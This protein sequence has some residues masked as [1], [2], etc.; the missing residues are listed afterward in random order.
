MRKIN[1]ICFSHIFKYWLVI[2]I[3]C[4]VYQL[5]SQELDNYSIKTVVLDPGHGGK[6]P[7]A[8]GKNCKEKDITLKVAKKVGALINKHYPQIKVAYTHETDTF[9]ALKDR[10]KFA[11]EQNADLFISIHCNSF[12]KNRNVSGIETYVMGSHKAEDNLN[13]SL[14]E[15]AV[16]TYEENYESKYEGYDPNSSESLII[17]SMIQN[18][19]LE[20]SLSFASL[21]QNQ[22]LQNTPFHDRGVRQ[23]GFW[24][25]VGTTMPS[26]LVE[27][28][29]I[30]NAKDEAYMRSEKGQNALAQS[31][32]EAFKTYK[33][34]VDYKNSQTANNHFTAPQLSEPGI[35]FKIQLVASNKKVSIQQSE[36]KMISNVEELRV[37]NKYKYCTGKSKN[38]Q[39]VQNKLKEVRKYFPDAFIIAFK[40]EKQVPLQDALNEI[41]SQQS[42]NN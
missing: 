29:Y 13:V 19:Y 15:N 16:I 31:I 6:D 12:P 20:Q 39:E 33:Q 24:V 36:L 18:I 42:K 8:L 5:S 32:F 38:Y 26:I 1:N 34:D 11:N 37:D 3:T 21:L 28:G 4:S 25:L 14:R 9:I 17:F 7:G 23:A 27:M 41:N 2:A 22:V 35:M 10:S 30:S 40:D